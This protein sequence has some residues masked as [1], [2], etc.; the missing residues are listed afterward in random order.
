MIHSQPSGPDAVLNDKNLSMVQIRWLLA[1]ILFIAFTLRITSI[2]YLQLYPSS[3]AFE[4]HTLAKNLSEGRGFTLDNIPTA[5][6]APGYPL[7]LAVL[8]KL[9]GPNILIGQIA[10]AGLETIQCFLLFLLGRKLFSSLAGLISACFWAAFPVSVIQSNFLMPEPLFILLMGTALVIIFSNYFKSYTGK[11][12]LGL[13]I[14]CGSLIKPFFILAPFSLL[15]WMI[16]KKTALKEIIDTISIVSI[17]AAL[18]ISPWLIKNISQFNKPMISSNGGINFWIGN[19]PDATGGFRFQSV[20][21]P[22]DSISSEIDRDRVGY[23]LGLKFIKEQP[24]KA[25]TLLPKKLA[26]LF[27]S[28]SPYIISL[29]NRGS[30]SPSTRYSTLYR[31]TPVILHVL[32]NI[33]Y[34]FFMIMGIV[35]FHFLPLDKRHGFQSMIIIIGCWIIIHLIFFGSH[36]FHYPLM[37]FFVL[38]TTSIILNRKNISLTTNRRTLFSCAILI[39]IFLSILIAEVITAITRSNL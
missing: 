9:F 29:I 15:F 12:S 27:S 34:L 38:A 14:G 31:K 36:R 26:Y 19:N 22:F 28:D 17:V 2:F 6:R 16:L 37:P 5:Y 39:I 30:H 4:F 24:I 33:H 21:N 11:I 3:D 23:Q 8:Y 13:I 18:T 20:N 10:Q 32:I 1:L 7:F 35:G 25:I